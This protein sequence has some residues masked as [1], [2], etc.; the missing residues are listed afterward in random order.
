MESYNS[1][2][3]FG[4]MQ[5]DLDRSVNMAFN[6]IHPT[7]VDA[8]A[9][10]SGVDFAPPEFIAYGNGHIPASALVQVEGHGANFKLWAPAA[11]GYNLLRQAAMETGFIDPFLISAYRD[12]DTQVRLKAEKGKQAATP[13]KSKHGWGIAVDWNRGFRHRK[14]DAGETGLEWLAQH[15]FKFGYVHPIWARPGGSNPEEWHWEYRGHL[16]ERR[17]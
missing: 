8:V 14:N 17:S 7:E 2:N 12:F 10:L 6:S 1:R 4:D 15:A 11:I 3:G 13:G 16:V 5:G 9:G